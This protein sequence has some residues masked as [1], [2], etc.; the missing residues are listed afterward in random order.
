MSA[1]TPLTDADRWPWLDALGA[2]LA[3]QGLRGRSGLRRFSVSGRVRQPGVIEF[4]QRFNRDGLR[5][6][7]SFNERG[8][9]R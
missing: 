9:L 3:A 8:H 5:A 7:R 4:M 2:W 6:L 1:G